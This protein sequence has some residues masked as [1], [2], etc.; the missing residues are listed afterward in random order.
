[1]VV[2]IER[3]TSWDQAKAF[4]LAVADEIAAAAPE[5][6][7]A[8]MSKAARRGKIFIDYL[9]NDRGATVIAAYSTRARTGAPVSLPI[10]WNELTDK[11]RSDQFTVANV[12]ARLERLKRDPWSE[13]P[14]TRQSI[15]ASVLKRL[16]SL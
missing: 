1:M 9:R 8:T 11:L 13:L 12:P 3:R 4:C 16:R 6:Y 2:P 15:T 5:R 7:I 14:Q 10:A